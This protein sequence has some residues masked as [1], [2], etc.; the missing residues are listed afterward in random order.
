[1]K[2]PFGKTLDGTGAGLYTL[3]NS[4]G[5]E[6]RIT[7]YGGILVSLLVPDRNGKFGDVVLGCDNLQGYLN[8]HHVSAQRSV[9]MQIGLRRDGLP[10]R[11]EP[12]S[13]PGTTREIIYMAV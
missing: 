10:W 3:R 8:E 13:S 12:I 7:N 1:M 5:L 9:D 11:T 2:E 6:A 4:N